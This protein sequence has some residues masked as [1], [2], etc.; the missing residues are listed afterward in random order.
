MNLHV[1]SKK[2]KGLKGF[3]VPT[4]KSEFFVLNHAEK[5]VQRDGF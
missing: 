2:Q 5:N 3:I 4:F 1:L